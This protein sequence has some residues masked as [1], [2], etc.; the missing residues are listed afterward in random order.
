[1][2]DSRDRQWLRVPEVCDYVWRNDPE[3]IVFVGKVKPML[4]DAGRL[5]QSDKFTGQSS[6]YAVRIIE[7]VFRNMI[8][9]FQKV[10]PGLREQ[11]VT[12]VLTYVLHVC[13]RSILEFLPKPLS[14]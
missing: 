11:N 6:D 5:S 4:A 8:P 1:M 3:S 10:N 7:T 9:D 2:Y 14:P 13:E 12:L